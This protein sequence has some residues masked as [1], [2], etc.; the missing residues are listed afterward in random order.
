MTTHLQPAR[1]SF[2]VLPITIVPHLHLSPSTTIMH[3]PRH[4]LLDRLHPQQLLRPSVSVRPTFDVHPPLTPFSLVLSPSHTGFS[5]WRR[6]QFPVYSFALWSTL[7]YLLNLY[8]LAPAVSS[9]AASLVGILSMV[10]GL[11]VSFRSSS[12][13]DRWYEGRRLWAG[14]TGT[15]RNVLRQLAFALPP[16][17]VATTTT[18]TVEPITELANLFVAFPYATMYHLRDQS[19]L[20]TSSLSSLLPSRIVESYSRLSSSKQGLKTI[21]EREKAVK[22]YKEKYG[23]ELDAEDELVRAAQGTNRASFSNGSGGGASLPL[24]LIRSIHARESRSSKP[25][26][27]VQ[28]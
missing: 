17:G 14:L 16:S 2:C 3:R 22:E 11:M 5:V 24:F 12:S 8:S 15:T 19:G 10:T 13:Y 20:T 4:S 27:F 9:G 26:S 1:S 28:S 25:R 23:V 6:V 18:T 21:D 7:I